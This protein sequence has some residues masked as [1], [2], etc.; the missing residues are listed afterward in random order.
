[1][2]TAGTTA[3]SEGDKIEAIFARNA[4]QRYIGGSVLKVHKELGYP[5]CF[6]K[7]DCYAEYCVALH[8]IC[9]WSQ[10]YPSTFWYDIEYDNGNI[11]KQV[12]QDIVRLPT[13]HV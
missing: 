11:E 12:H 7:G 6:S 10:C 1:M 4:A 5:G 3:F 13:K 2:S 8:L 9:C